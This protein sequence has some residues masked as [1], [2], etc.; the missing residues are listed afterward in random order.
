MARRPHEINIYKIADEAGVSPATVSRVINRRLGV[1]EATRR[2]I[3][4]ILRRYDFTPDYPAMRSPRIAVVTPWEDPTPY[5]QKALKGVYSYSRDNGLSINLH[6]FDGKGGESLLKSIRDQQYSGVVAL[7]SEYYRKELD[8][9]SG[10]DLP[11]VLLDASDAD[12]KIGFVDNDS[13]TGSC[14]AARHLLSLGHRRIGYL[15]Y[16]KDSLNQFQRF[17][18]YEN[19]LRSAGIEID[20]RWIVRHDASTPPS[21]RGKGGYEGMRI[22]L[23]RAPEITAVMAV[24][25]GM[26]LGV[27]SA[28]HEAGLRIPEDISVIGFD[29]YPETEMW[30]P[31]LSTIDHPIEAAARLAVQSIHAGLR[32]PGAWTPPREILPAIFVPRKSSGPAKS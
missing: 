13:Y 6:I 29:N 4:E 23:E 16:S 2:K 3:S 14:E 24:D 9:F 8:V 19:T 11:V 32:N 31:A 5:I 15:R 1:G 22:L 30:Y 12:S 18:A 10:S 21:I 27:L 20:E 28:V 25:D 17:K 7:L 26:A